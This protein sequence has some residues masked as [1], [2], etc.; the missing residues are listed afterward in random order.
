MAVLETYI[1]IGSVIQSF[2]S[3]HW[4]FQE[5]ICVSYFNIYVPYFFASEMQANML[6]LHVPSLCTGS[7]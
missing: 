1:R 2:C 7:Q 5:D 4:I 3:I 6:K